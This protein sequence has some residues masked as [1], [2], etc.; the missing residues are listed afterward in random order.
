MQI[1][2]RIRQAWTALAERSLSAPPIDAVETLREWLTD[3][4]PRIS[5]TTRIALGGARGV[6]LF[7]ATDSSRLPLGVPAFEAFRAALAREALP[8]DPVAFV[9]FVDQLC[10]GLAVYVRE[11][12]CCPVCQYDLGL[13]VA[14]GRFIDICGTDHCFPSPKEALPRARTPVRLP[15]PPADARPARRD[16]VRAH[17]PNARLA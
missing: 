6:Q 10:Y 16:E 13:F 8:S 3:E 7:L 14:G 9:A 2:T 4:A 11:D 17:F 12:D 5:A 15:A 1:D